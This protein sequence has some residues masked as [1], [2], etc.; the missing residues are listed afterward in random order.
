MLQYGFLL[1]GTYLTLSAQVHSFV[2]LTANVSDLKRIAQKFIPEVVVENIADI[3]YKASE[4][5]A[6]TNVSE[7]NEE[8][9]NYKTRDKYASQKES[10]SETSKDIEDPQSISDEVTTKPSIISIDSIL[11]AFSS[12][13]TNGKNKKSTKYKEPKLNINKDD[14]DSNPDNI[15]SKKLHHPKKTKSPKLLNKKPQIDESEL[16]EL[17]HVQSKSF[18]PSLDVFSDQNKSY[19]KKSEESKQYSDEDSQSDI[20]LKIKPEKSKSKTEK[21]KSKSKHTNKAILRKHRAKSQRRHSK[22]DNSEDNTYKDS[23][24][25]SVT[26]TTSVQRNEFD[27]YVNLNYPKSELVATLDL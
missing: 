10:E 26:L 24:R 8:N 19:N 7:E 14:V 4:D 21:R 13:G 22:Y 17:P 1:F 12:Q 2:L 11:K 6:A 23:T 27:Q 5:L 3:I 15:K 16:S 9:Y 18:T 20:A 25:K